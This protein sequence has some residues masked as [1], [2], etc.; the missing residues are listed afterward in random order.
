MFEQI[1]WYIAVP[2][3]VVF[4]IQ[5]LLTF[6]GIVGDHVD[7]DTHSNDFHSTDH[8]VDHAYFPIFTIRNLVVF[9][10][11]FGWTSITMYKT[12]PGHN[13]LI[14]VV[15]FFA[16]LILMILTA[17]MFL[18]ISKLTSNGIEA[19]DDTIIN[20]EAKVYLK[21]PGNKNGQGK[22]TVVV[23]GRNIERQ[24]TTNGP[25]ISTGAIVKIVE[26]KKDGSVSVIKL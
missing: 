22:I 8:N 15:S 14:I 23:K 19:I 5:S 7:I 1:L 16:G 24:A 6:M 11:M 26:L 18:G 4:T 13:I 9:L 17:L 20:S 21:I 2:A 3:T 10:M 12:F 25:E